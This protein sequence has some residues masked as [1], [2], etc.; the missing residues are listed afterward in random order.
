MRSDVEAALQ[1]L[2]AQ[3]R[4]DAGRARKALTGS[5]DFAKRKMDDVRARAADAITLVERGGVHSVENSTALG[6]IL[7]TAMIDDA[8]RALDCVAKIAASRSLVE[9]YGA[10]YTYLRAQTDVNLGRWRASADL[11][12]R[13]A[14]AIT[15]QV[16]E[17]LR[18]KFR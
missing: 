3:D 16:D 1:Q 6:R 7:Q 18:K 13:S 15:G 2:E 17:H 8:K 14:G 11:A 10:Q 12:G 4:K 9:A 5:V